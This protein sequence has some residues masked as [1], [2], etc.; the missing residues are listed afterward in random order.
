MGNFENPLQGRDILPLR[1]QETAPADKETE[2][3]NTRRVVAGA[4]NTLGVRES[5]GCAQGRPCTK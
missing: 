5:R 4:T 2:D 3:L 1:I